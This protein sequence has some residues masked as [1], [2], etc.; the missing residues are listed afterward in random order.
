LR[1]EDSDGGISFFA[2]TRVAEMWKWNAGLS[3]II[4]SLVSEFAWRFGI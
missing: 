4:R 1:F 3:A 2:H